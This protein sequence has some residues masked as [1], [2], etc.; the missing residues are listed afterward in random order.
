M[1][2]IT[3]YMPEEGS[4]GISVSLAEAVEVASASTLIFLSGQLPPVIDRLVD[5]RVLEAYGDTETQTLGVL[6]KIEQILLTKNYDMNCVVKLSA[7]LCPD[8]R[9]GSVVD[10]DG[11]SRAY[12]TVFSEKNGDLNVPARTRLQVERFSNPGHL[13]EIDIVAAKLAR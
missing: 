7:F 1:Q 10:A 9:S 6:R 12:A 3:R 8:P 11:F 5:P 13:V 4:H 2:A